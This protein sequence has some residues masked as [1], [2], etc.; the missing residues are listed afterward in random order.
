M[1]V[2]GLAGVWLIYNG[3]FDDGLLPDR[4]LSWYLIRS[5]GVAAY[6]LLTLSVIWGLALSSS[7]V[8]DWSPGPLTMLLHSTLSWSSLILGLMHGL[9]LLLDEYFTY[10]ITDVLVPFV[11]PYRPLAAGLGTVA[12]WL[13]VLVT[14]SFAL[15]KHFFSH[16]VWKLLHY[17]SYA[18]FMLV[19]TH[20]LL[21]G[22]D[23]PNLGFR[24]LFGLSVL[25]TVIL[26]G[27]RI[28][29]KQTSGSKSHRAQP[30]SKRAADQ[31]PAEADHRRTAPQ[32]GD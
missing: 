24:L 31:A 18:A 9:M 1:L 30:A 23:A 19:T 27:Y 25:L 11:G 6:I 21:A 7:V 10:R 20:G 8:K 3:T 28:G 29:V 22:T 12:L 16:R 32:V 2:V 4:N 15:K 13:L 26:L 5:S 17:L 14:P